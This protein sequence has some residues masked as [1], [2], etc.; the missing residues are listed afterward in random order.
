[1]KHFNCTKE[2][3]QPLCVWKAVCV[4]MQA[5]FHQEGQGRGRGRKRLFGESFA[6]FA[7]MVMKPEVIRVRDK[8]DAERP[9]K[10]FTP[11]TW[12]HREK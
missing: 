5:P 12:K 11:G 9:L 7:S 3:T 1:M 2:M 8:P 4:P 6:E 10:G